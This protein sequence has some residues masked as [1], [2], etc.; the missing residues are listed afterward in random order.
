VTARSC[1][2]VI[3]TRTSPLR[4]F[5][6]VLC[7]WRMLRMLMYPL[8]MYMHRMLMYALCQYMVSIVPLVDSHLLQFFLLR[9]W[10][11]C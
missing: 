3:M 8:C 4:F 6:L 10:D 5:G 9:R 11:A 1:A 2:S 7:K